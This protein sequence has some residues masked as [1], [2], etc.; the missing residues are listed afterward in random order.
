[1]N[2]SKSEFLSR[3]SHEIRTPMNAVIGMTKIA[4]QSQNL[5]EVKNYL[6]NIDGAAKQLM[7]IINDIFDVSKIE[8]HKLELV[9]AS[10][11]FKKTMAAVYEQFKRKAEEKK[12]T[13]TFKMD[14][15]ITTLYVGDEARLSQ[16]VGNLLSNAVKFTPEGGEIVLSA[17]QHGRTQS[18]AEV[19][20]SISDTG[21]GISQKNIAKLFFPFEQVDGSKSRK[22]GG[23][24]LGLVL[25]KNIAELMG[26]RLDV[27]SEEGKGSVFTFTAK[28]AIGNDILA[29]PVGQNVDEPDPAHK[30]ETAQENESASESVTDGAP[31]VPERQENLE[32]EST[33]SLNHSG[34]LDVENFLPFI[35][36]KRGLENLKSNVKLYAILLRSY[37]KN[38]FLEKI[39]SHA[40]AGNFKD[41]LTHALAL[42]SIAISVGLDDLRTK[43][44]LLEETLR[45]ARADDV[46]MRRLAAST[47]KTRRLVPG[48]IGA[49]EEGKLP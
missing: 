26:G 38:D 10:F 7:D 1:M 20:V 49:L 27:K 33:K 12:Q 42:K 40:T 35:N 31:E 34:S 22:Y 23:T 15:G 14:G 16:V 25:S 28:F 8:E 3:M 19:E 21:I 32:S 11:D 41:A 30:I 4:K 29:E 5:S 13:L 24:G 36:V 37:Q 47:E 6:E 45:S 39:E 44:D 18:E 43:M 48:L 9:S 46:L 17:R 2:E